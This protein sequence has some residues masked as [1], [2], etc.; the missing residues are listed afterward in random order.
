M[1]MHPEGDEKQL[2]PLLKEM[3]QR[4]RGLLNPSLYL[5][6]T[7]GPQ[8]GRLMAPLAMAAAL[9]KVACLEVLLSSSLEHV[10]EA[11]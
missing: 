6:F 4:D 1:L 10:N 3:V 7:D 5:P 2:L 8:K 11:S 9:G